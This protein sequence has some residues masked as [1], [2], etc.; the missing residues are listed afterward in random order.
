[1][2]K[3]DCEC[4]YELSDSVLGNPNRAHFIAD[5]DLCAFYDEP[6]YED[7]HIDIPLTKVRRYFNDMF[8]CP[9]CNNLIIFIGGN[10]LHFRPINKS[11][12]AGITNS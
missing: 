7:P 12:S 3:F 2:G 6:E 9:E 4:G 8:Q 11:Q 1:M 10:D 5:K